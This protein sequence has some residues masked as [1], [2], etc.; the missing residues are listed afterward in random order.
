M[1]AVKT[2]AF[3][4]GRGGTRGA[5]GFPGGILY[6]EHASIHRVT[7]RFRCPAKLF[8]QENLGKRLSTDFART[9]SRQLFDRSSSVLLR[10]VSL[11][12]SE[13]RIK[14]RIRSLALFLSLH[15]FP[16]IEFVCPLCAR[17]RRTMV[18][19]SRV[20]DDPRGV[21]RRGK[22]VEFRLTLDDR[23]IKFGSGVDA[24]HREVGW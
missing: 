5:R 3:L 24:K 11:R 18:L 4:L 20:E 13:R 17:S 6:T 16:P 15:T 10:S 12:F 23:W 9:C 1:F 2:R 7:I 8:Y 22:V 14:R 21:S 19:R